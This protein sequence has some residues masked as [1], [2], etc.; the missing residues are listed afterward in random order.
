MGMMHGRKAKG[1]SREPVDGWEVDGWWFP[2][3]RW[4]LNVE[5]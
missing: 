4:A 3:E 1:A 2:V 5:R